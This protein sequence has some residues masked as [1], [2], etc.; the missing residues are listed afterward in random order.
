M[1]TV[2]VYLGRNVQ[3]L[4]LWRCLACS[5]ETVGYEQ[6]K[7]CMHCGAK[8]IKVEHATETGTPITR[9]DAEPTR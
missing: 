6:P 5:K 2:L 9:V 8:A 4:M 3:Q 7:F 1:H